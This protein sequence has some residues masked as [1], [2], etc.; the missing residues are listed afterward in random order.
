MWVLSGSEPIRLG[1]LVEGV[2]ES[3]RR[4]QRCL[5]RGRN[6]YCGQPAVTRKGDVDPRCADH[7]G[8]R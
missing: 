3:S 6:G 5:Y 4:A 1:D 7:L 8:R 2:R